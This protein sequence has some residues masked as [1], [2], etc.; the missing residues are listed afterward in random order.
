[1][2]ALCTVRDSAAFISAFS[3]PGF[4]LGGRLGVRQSIEGG[5]VGSS[6]GGGGGRRVGVGGNNLICS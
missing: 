3:I 1:M 6:G 5:A 4:N 2:L